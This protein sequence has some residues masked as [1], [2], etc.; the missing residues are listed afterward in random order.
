[1]NL[2]ENIKIWIEL[3]NNIKELNQKI[4][5]LREKKNSYNENIINHV[6]SNNLDKA[7]IKT[8]DS[9]LKFIDFNYSQPITLKYLEECFIK[10]FN[11][12]E[13]AKNLL[14]FIKENRNIKTTKEI[15]RT[16]V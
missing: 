6:I 12:E 10:F 15:K 7:I 14:L 1:M 9:N 5:V 4:K 11:N 8:R 13:K 2:Q 16:Y 3:D